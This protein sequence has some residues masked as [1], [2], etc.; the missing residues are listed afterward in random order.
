MNG[1]S[2]LRPDDPLYERNIAD[3]DENQVDK[4]IGDV[5]KLRKQRDS[6]RNDRDNIVRNI[7][8][9]FGITPNV[10]TQEKLIIALEGLIGSGSNENVEK[11]LEDANAQLNGIETIAHIDGV[12]VKRNYKV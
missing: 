5:L 11:I 8:N 10:D 6:A 2:F 4:M 1:L 9:R 3:K 12:E 7:A